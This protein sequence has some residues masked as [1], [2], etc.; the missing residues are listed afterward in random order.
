MRGRVDLKAAP[1]VSGGEATD[2]PGSAIPTLKTAPSTPPKRQIV[3]L[4]RS[5][6]MVSSVR[7]PATVT[8]RPCGP[9]SSSATRSSPDAST[10]ASPRWA[11]NPD[12]WR[13]TSRPIPD[14]A[15]VTMKTRPT[16]G[17][18]G[19]RT[20]LNAEGSVS[21]CACTRLPS[22][23]RSI[24]AA[25]T[26]WTWAATRPRALASDSSHPAETCPN[27]PEPSAHRPHLPRA[28]PSLAPFGSTRG[29]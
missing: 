14:A 21:S 1:P 4:T 15:P 13:A 28:S 27:S 22:L 6:T 2:S 17:S 16:A 19:R 20:S 29:G 3:L 23:P 25:A 11:P 5:S 10:S 12:K 9:R 26:R 18:P 24:K 7:S 8:G